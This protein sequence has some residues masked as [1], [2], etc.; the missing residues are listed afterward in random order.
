M[1][2]I[3]TFL[4]HRTYCS[5]KVVLKSLNVVYLSAIIIKFAPML[6][7]VNRNLAKDSIYD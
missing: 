5:T 1:C 4:A 2:K 6:T 7:I 3:T